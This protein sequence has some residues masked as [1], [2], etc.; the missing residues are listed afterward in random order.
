M[1]KLSVIQLTS[2]PDVEQNLQQIAEQLAK[3]PKAEQHLVLLPECCLFFGGKDSEQH[4]LAKQ[5]A[6]TQVLL[7]AL[8]ELARQHQVYLVAGTIPLWHGV[9]GKF[10]NTCCVLAPTGELLAQY[11]KIH[12][13]D[14]AVNDNEKT[15]CESRYTQAGSQA[16]VTDLPFAKLG[17]TV[18]YDLRFPELFSSLSRQGATIITVPSAFTQV[19][20]QA[21]WHALLK[22]RAIENQVYIMAAGQVGTHANG[23]QTYGHSLI[24]NPW[25]EIVAELEQG[26]GSVSIEFESELIEKI[27]QDMPVL[28]H[29]RFRVDLY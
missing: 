26:I 16:V 8:S 13:F 27:R 22:A 18:C 21:H 15:Y 28:Q 6:P 5:D 23:R 25:G 14:V 2:V 10:T 17:L 7:S 11:D 29:K 9:S 1:A 12:L 4:Q 19:T 24:I 20:G 3:L